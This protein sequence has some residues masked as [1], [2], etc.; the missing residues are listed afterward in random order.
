MPDKSAS[1]A[2]DGLDE[3]SIGFTLAIR[4]KVPNSLLAWRIEKDTEGV[5]AILEK[6]WSTPAYD[7]GIALPR[8][9]VTYPLHDGEHVSRIHALALAELGTPFVTATPEDLGK[10]TEP[11]VSPL[12]AMLHSRQIAA[13]RIGKFLGEQLVP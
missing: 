7:D 10:S 1:F 13:D 9:L 3:C 12:N 2:V 8:D 4:D 11:F 6:T 5:I